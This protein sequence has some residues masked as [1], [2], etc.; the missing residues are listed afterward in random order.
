MKILVIGTRGIPDIQGGIETHCQ[1]LYTRLANLG[2]D[3]T[4]ITRKYYVKNKDSDNYKNVKLK[5]F[6]SRFFNLL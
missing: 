5:H 3:I 1:E 2:A 4:V 6:Y